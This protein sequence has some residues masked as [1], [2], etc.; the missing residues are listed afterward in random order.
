MSKK[1]ANFNYENTILKQGYF[2]IAGLDEVGR[3][4]LAGPVVACAVVVK[5]FF[6][7]EFRPN[8]RDSKQL[9]EKQREKWFEFLTNTPEIKWGIGIVSEKII[10]EINILE[11]AKLAMKKALDNLKI[12]PDFLLIDGNFLLEDLNINQKAVIKGDEKIFSCAAASIIAKVTRDRLMLKYAKKYPA[13]GFEKHKGYGTRFHLAALKKHGPCEI[14]R[15][16]FRPVSF[17]R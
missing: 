11:A 6:Y 5:K 17:F 16:S 3:G 13:Y 7:D 12:A 9:S 14:H 8:I 10:D 1:L 2:L 4:P 15:R